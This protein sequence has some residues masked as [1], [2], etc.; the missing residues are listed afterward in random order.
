MALATLFSSTADDFTRTTDKLVLLADSP[1]PLNNVVFIYA[2][3][4]PGYHS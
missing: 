2:I 1:G 3:D 4:V